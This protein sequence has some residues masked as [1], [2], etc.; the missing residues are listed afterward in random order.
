MALNIFLHLLSIWAQKV[1]KM[2]LGTCV[3]WQTWSFDLF[4]YLRQPA[5][6]PS[7]L[8]EHLFGPLVSFRSTWWQF[9]GSTHVLLFSQI[10]GQFAIRGVNSC[11]ALLAGGVGWVQVCKLLQPRLGGK[12]WLEPKR[13]NPL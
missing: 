7:G 9:L 5:A 11:F 2:A 1:E 10:W 4:R 13:P 3:I 8:I 6:R 12:R